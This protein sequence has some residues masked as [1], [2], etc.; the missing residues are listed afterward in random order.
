M[1]KSV[2]IFLIFLIYQVFV[3]DFGISMT[4]E[5]YFSIRFISE[6]N[7]NCSRGKMFIIYFNS[8]DVK[9]N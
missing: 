6:M 2:N 3:S 7:N 8:L 5:I 4:F 1:C 9:G